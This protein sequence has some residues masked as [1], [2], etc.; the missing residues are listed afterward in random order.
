VLT[1]T[2]EQLQLMLY[3]GAIRFA[4]QGRD[5]LE[6]RDFETS[7]EK[8]SRAQ[9]IVI[10]MESGL[11]REVNPELC[12][13]M[14]AIYGFLYRK[15]VEASVNKDA[16]AVDDALKI[17][18]MERETWVMLIEKIHNARVEHDL[19]LTEP[20]QAESSLCVEG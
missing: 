1:A 20:S 4:L 19:P 18:R 17:L 7:F 3:D 8:L 2:A 5:A 13:R 12:D 14:A 15:L 16:T 6:A 9:A 10:E 11:R